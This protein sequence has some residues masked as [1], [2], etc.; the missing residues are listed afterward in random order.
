MNT[1][2][3][4]AI[5]DSVKQAEAEVVPSSSSVKAKLSL[6]KLLLEIKRSFSSDFRDF[7]CGGGWLVG[8]VLKMKLMLTQL[9]TKLELKLISSGGPFGPPSA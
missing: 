5:K 1:L 2:K 9:S 7:F 4:I 3:T 6:V 8:W